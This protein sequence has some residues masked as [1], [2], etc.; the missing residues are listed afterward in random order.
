MAKSKAIQATVQAL[1]EVAQ[2][3]QRE[4]WAE[5]AVLVAVDDKTSVDIDSA[6]HGNYAMVQASAY[7]D[8]ADLCR[9][10][11]YQF[12]HPKANINP[13]V[14]GFNLKS[15][16]KRAYESL[17][18]LRT[19]FGF[20]PDS[21][22]QFTKMTRTAQE[23]YVKTARRKHDLSLGNL[24]SAIAAH[25]VHSGS[26]I[27]SYFETAAKRFKDNLAEHGSVIKPEG[28]KSDKKEPP[29]DGGM[30]KPSEADNIVSKAEAILRL[31]GEGTKGS[32]GAVAA[33][34]QIFELAASIKKTLSGDAKM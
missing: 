28:A 6:F 29:K 5:S 19:T 34:E 33:L 22:E 30:L 17:F 24:V 3:D 1:A 7:N 10:V 23:W 9:V 20:T 2:A 31:V 27:P 16:E 11:V 4:T 25:M 8:A 15:A 32:V 18:K 21:Q 13:D 26:S 12:L 14:S